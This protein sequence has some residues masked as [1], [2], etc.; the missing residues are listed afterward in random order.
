MTHDKRIERLA[1][2]LRP[3]D[4]VGPLVATVGVGYFTDHEALK[5]WWDAQGFTKPSHPIVVS[6]DKEA[7]DAEARHRESRSQERSGGGDDAARSEG[8]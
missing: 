2:A 6:L 5:E 8:H 1:A 7:A 4:K 3:K